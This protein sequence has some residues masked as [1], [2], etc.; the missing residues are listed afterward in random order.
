[1]WDKGADPTGHP[2]S[3]LGTGTAVVRVHP[4]MKE[5]STQ[6]SR[7][8]GHWLI[9]L[10]SFTWIG[11]V[12][13]APYAASRG[14]IAG[15]LIYAFFDRICHQI[16][17]RSFW[18]FGHQLAVCHRCLGL[19]VGFA[20]GL[21]LLAHLPALTWRL[22]QRPRLLVLFVAPMLLDVVWP[23]N[24]FLTRFVSGFVASF[25]VGLLLWAALE[26][27]R[28]P[29]TVIETVAGGANVPSIHR[30]EFV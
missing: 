12:V 26:Q 6:L 9:V 20:A 22:L 13:G 21:L 25:P 3:C 16:P 4:S 15:P 8:T 24:Y 5:F 18:A 27:L 10:A 2:G 30:G 14:W 11:A 23:S 17:E 28:Q 1:M 29:G 19:Y 7:G